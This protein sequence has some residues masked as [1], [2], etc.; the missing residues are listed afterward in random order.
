LKDIN[1]NAE[2]AIL[3]G[4]ERLSNIEKIY[5]QVIEEKRKEIITEKDGLVKINIDKLLNL[6]PT[7]AYLF[8]FLYPYG[9][10][11]EI[12]RSI[13]GSAGKQTGKTFY[14]TTHRLVKDRNYFL[15]TEVN[16]D[17]EYKEYQVNL[18]DKKI[19]V[20]V[21]MNFSSM[22]NSDKLKIPT[23]KNI[24]YF[25]LDK[26]QF[27]LTIRQ[28]KRGDYFYPYGMKGKKKLSDFFTD[29]KLSLVEKENIW[30][31]CSGGHIIWIIGHRND[32]RYKVTGKTKRIF[33]AGLTGH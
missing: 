5:R 13:S 20:P 12:I 31:L 3:S 14:S 25:D 10:S 16:K 28:W 9:F 23:E 21:K 6:N 4:M 24:A 26:L 30:L 22:P 27:P 11:G 19:T 15:I 1:P 7:D 2:N 29:R 8:E 33:I 32:N 17:P 18:K